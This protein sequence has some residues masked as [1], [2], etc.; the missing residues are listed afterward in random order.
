MGAMGGLWKRLYS[1]IVF[2]AV[3]GLGGLL[4]AGLAIPAVSLVAG[5]GTGAA[6]ALQSL[7]VELE[8]PP[9]AQRS[10]LLNADGSVLTYF[11]DENRI[12]V[13]LDKI[14]PIMLKAQVAIEDLSAAPP[15]PP[16]E[17]VPAAATP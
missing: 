7:P 2:L 14:A 3:A 1:L 4:A 17:A 16:A 5:T 12:Y 15:A 11:Y 6:T 9:L 10:R 8:T 13:G